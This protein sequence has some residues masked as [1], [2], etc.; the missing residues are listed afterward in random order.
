MKSTPKTR[1]VAAYKARR[2]KRKAKIAEL[3]NGPLTEH[4][5]YLRST[6]M[7]SKAI[8]KATVRQRKANRLRRRY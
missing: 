2:A 6:G 5:A 3:S 4:I 7:P 8:L 1:G